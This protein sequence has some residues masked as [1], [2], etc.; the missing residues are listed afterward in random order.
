MLIPAPC[1]WG[2]F[3]IA[4]SECNSA[5]QGELKKRNCST[6]RSPAKPCPD[7]MGGMYM[8]RYSVTVVT[9]VES[10]SKLPKIILYI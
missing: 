1:T 10:L 7:N 2:G 5:K 6:V 8:E 4:R 3:Q 9:V